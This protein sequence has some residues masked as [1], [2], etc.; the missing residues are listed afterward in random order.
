MLLRNNQTTNTKFLQRAKEVLVGR[1][2]S[3]LGKRTE[4]ERNIFQCNLFA[5]LANILIV[6]FTKGPRF[7]DRKQA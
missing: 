2:S 1:R 5:P 7:Q 3:S 6:I 4:Q